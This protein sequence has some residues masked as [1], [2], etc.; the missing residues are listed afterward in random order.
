M[1][2]ILSCLLSLALVIYDNLI[3]R[4]MHYGNI[5]DWDQTIP[6]G[7]LWSMFKV[8]ASMI[9]GVWSAFEYMQQMLSF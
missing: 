7:A 4:L 9:K 8:F 1:K 3:I 2:L 5:I 6:L